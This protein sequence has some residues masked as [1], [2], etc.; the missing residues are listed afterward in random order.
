MLGA[1][2]VQITYQDLAKYKEDFYINLAK[3]KLEEHQ[4][5]SAKK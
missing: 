3:E 1:S 2:K 5:T 4:N